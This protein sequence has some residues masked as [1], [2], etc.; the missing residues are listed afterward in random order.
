MT[1]SDSP[2]PPNAGPLETAKKQLLRQTLWVWFGTMLA[3]RLLH[4]GRRISWINDNLMLLTG[5]VLLYVPLAVLWRRKEKQNFFETSFAQLLKSLFWVLALSAAIFPILEIGNRYFQEIAFHRHYVGGHYRGLAR[6][7]LFQFFLVGIPEE[8]FYRGY[9][10]T[11]FNRIWEK[12]IRLLGTPVGW[13]LLFTS[14][15]FALSHRLITFQWWHF[16]IFFP[17]LA[18]GWLRERTGAITAGALFHALCNVY[19]LWVAMNYR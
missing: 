8:F 14:A 4:E 13:S 18:F 1:P 3:I 16:S 2:V 19:S 6:A 5:L 11:Q 12:R 7:A 17:S 10:Q 15:L 9:L